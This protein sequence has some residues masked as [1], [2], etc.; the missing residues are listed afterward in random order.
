MGYNKHTR[1]VQAVGVVE[2]R[3][4]RGQQRLIDRANKALHTDSDRR[5]K[6]GSPQQQDIGKKSSAGCAKAVVCC[7]LTQLLL[8]NAQWTSAS[9][10]LSKNFPS[11]RIV[12]NSP[13]H[14]GS[15]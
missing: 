14:N 11:S 1:E 6:T 15:I 4:P 10:I 3:W 2:R 5:R 9:L 13:Y 7:G 8:G 12:E